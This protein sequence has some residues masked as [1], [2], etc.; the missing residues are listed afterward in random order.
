M[1]EEEVKEE[2]IIE[3]TITSEAAALSTGVISATVEGGLTV[4]MYLPKA[5]ISARNAYQFDVD[6]EETFENVRCVLQDGTASD[7][8]GKAFTSCSMETRIGTNPTYDCITCNLLRG[9]RLYADGSYTLVITKYTKPEPEP[10]EEV[11]E[12]FSINVTLTNQSRKDVKATGDLILTTH[13]LHNKIYVPLFTSTYENTTLEDKYEGNFEGQVCKDK[14]GNILTTVSPELKGDT[15]INSCKLTTRVGET[16]TENYISCNIKEDP[17]PEDGSLKL[18]NGGYYIVTITDYNPPSEDSDDTDSSGSTTVETTVPSIKGVIP[19]ALADALKAKGYKKARAVV[20]YP[21]PQDRKVVCQGVANPTMYT[22]NH[23]GDTSWITNSISTKQPLKDL[24]AQSSWFFRPV[25]PN[26]D[27][28]RDYQQDV[29][30]PCSESG[31]IDYQNNGIYT[32]KDIDNGAGR[33]KRVEIQGYFEEQNR[34]EVDWKTLTYHSPDIEFDTSTHNLDYASDSIKYSLVGNVKFTKTLSDIDIQTETPAISSKG[35]GFDKK[36][37]MRDGSQ[38]IISGLFW[39]DFGVDENR[40]DD[41]SPW[42]FESFKDQK[43]SAKW[44]VYLW[45]KKGSLNNDIERPTDKGVRSAV[46]KQKIVSNLRY[47]VTNYSGNSACR[48]TSQL[49]NSDTASFIKLLGVSSKYSNLY[50]GNVDTLLSPDDSDGMYFAIHHEAEPVDWAGHTVETFRS[51]EFT[52]SV[53]YKTF[54]INAKGKN[55]EETLDQCGI[56][57]YTSTS[58]S[59]TPYMWERTL[60]EFMENIG[61]GFTD[62][63][64]KKEGVRMQ[65]K[66]TPHLVM[67]QPSGEESVYS[68]LK[69]KDTLPVF[70]LQRDFGEKEEDVIF[71]GISEDAL[72]DN[73]WIPC[74]DPVSL[75]C[76]ARTGKETK[77]GTTVFYYDWGDSY[78]QRWDCLKTYAYTPEDINQ[79]VEIGSFMLESYVN[80]DGRYDRNRG[81]GSNLYMSPRN[82]NLLNPV[83]SQI[84]NFFSYRRLDKDAYER[85]AYPNQITW[86]KTKTSGA[87]VDL[88]TNVTLG[89]VM[90]VDGDKGPVNKLARF[91]DQLISFQDRGVSQILY[92][93]QVQIS[94]EQ[95]VP[96][97]LANSGK[98]QGKRYLSDSIGCVNKWSVCSTPSGI[99]FMDSIDKNIYLFNGQMS[100]ISSSLGMNT[101]VKNNI[102]SAN[103]KWTPY[104]DDAYEDFLNFVTY[105]DRQNQDV[106]FI[107]SDIALAYS[108]KLQVFTSFYDYGHTPYFCN[109]IDG[110]VWIRNEENDG[111]PIATLHRHQHGEYCSF[112]GKNKPYWM[113]LVSNPEPQLDKIF[114]N[115]EFRACVEGD[116]ELDSETGKFTPTLPFDALETWNEYQRGL[117]Y[118]SNRNGHSAMTHHTNDGEASLKRKFRIW[119]CDIPRDNGKT[120]GIGN[121]TL[122]E[123]SYSGK[124]AHPVDRMRN[125]WLYVKLVKKAAEKEALKKTEIHDILMTYFG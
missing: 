29:N 106:L 120:L 62:L 64:R 78:F 88:W 15:T 121:D 124:K 119:R 58:S 47:A 9:S 89:S 103:V 31:H 83:Y 16:V 77:D 91:N 80:I 102:P 6:Y 72:K 75:G 96:I 12:K 13:G 55:Q 49:F 45:N 66:S 14:N 48:F 87:D 99:Y 104:K 21:S 4:L 65:Y 100:N 73:I 79:V 27:Y 23:R 28:A 46:L 53:L 35:S 112:F 67:V 101:W 7:Y 105:N 52:D 84:N 37:F 98:V 3:L 20:V 113:T 111:N 97:E 60:G 118:L 95:G 56:Y 43:A 125:P 117:A 85:K 25:L 116:G 82:F 1:A 108:E 123:T 63:T 30:S 50:K 69:T 8:L 38:G 86:S 34:F 122:N 54:G 26:Y 68:K 107:N 32:T 10:P 93:E 17:V 115:L 41:N 92:N 22:K 114:T 70:E 81:Q 90:E 76:D 109:L 74:G 40:D 59:D 5:G 24:F 11:G 110:G 36:S 51:P 33:I 18:K 44:M 2:I 57:E 39:D 19:K 94:T 42:F 71:G 61:D